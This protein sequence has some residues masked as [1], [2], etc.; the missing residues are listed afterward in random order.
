MTILLV[1][2]IANLLPAEQKCLNRKSYNSDWEN[3]Y[4]AWH[5]CSTN[6]RII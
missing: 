5:R 4:T 1:K 3:S 2:S 6:L